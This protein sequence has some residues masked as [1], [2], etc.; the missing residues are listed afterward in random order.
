MDENKNSV[1]DK[2]QKKE[3]SLFEAAYDLFISKGIDKTSI[4]DIVKKAGVAKGTFYLYFKD[5]FDI[6]DKIIWSKNLD[7]LDKAIKN[8]KAR[9]CD[10]CVENIIYFAD[11]IIEYFKENKLLLKIMN[12]NFSWNVIKKTYVTTSQNSSLKDFFEYICDYMKIN[13]GYSK[14]QVEKTIFIIVDLIGSVCY[15]SIILHEPD[16]IDN[17]KPILFDTVRKI[18]S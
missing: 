14:E 8:T 16:E 2:K 13:K 9:K 3:K 5:K 18:L 11:F 12:K 15:C 17:M 1:T 6:V 7:I 4:D 10:D